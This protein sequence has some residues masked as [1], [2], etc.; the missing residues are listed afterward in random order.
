[1]LKSGLFEYALCVIFVCI[2]IS[3]F[4]ISQFNVI[5]WNNVLGNIAQT[6]ASVC[7][8]WVLNYVRHY[9]WTLRT[10]FSSVCVLGKNS[11][12]YCSLIALLG[13]SLSEGDM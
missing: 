12:L 6:A 4:F 7:L 8:E 10:T 13:I 11:A 2:I 9:V 3:Q 1:M 5:R